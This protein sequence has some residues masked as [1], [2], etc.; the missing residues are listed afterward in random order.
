[1]K[2]S[3]IKI[4]HVFIFLF[5]IIIFCSILSYIVPSG[6]FER[7]KRVINKVEQNVVVP[8]SYI[9]IPKY[10]SIKGV[11]IGDKVEGYAMPNS[12]FSVLIA[13]PK[14][15]SQS[16]TL[17]FFV[18]ILGAVFNLIVETKTIHAFLSELIKR[19]IKFPILLFFLIYLTIST[20]SAFMGIYLELL[21]L[22]PI[23]MILAKQNGYDAMFGFALGILPVYI[24]WSTAT[25]NPFTVQI[26]QQI[27]ELPIG[28][29]FGLRF[30]IFILGIIIG[31]SYLMRYG[32]RVKNKKIVSLTECE[33]FSAVDGNEI[34]NVKLTIKHILILIVLLIGYACILSAVQFMGWGLMEMSAGFLAIGIAVIFISGWSGDKS[35]EIF[36]EGLKSMIIPALI[37]GV[38]RG[39][40]VVMV[41]SQI[42]DS[43]LF[44]FSNTLANQSQSIAVTGMLI[45]QSFLN[46]FIP[47][48]SGQALVSMPLMTPLSDLLGFSRQTAVLA[49][50]FGDGFSNM[51]IPTN[52]VLMA[53]LGIGGISFGKWLRF[54]L[55]VFWILL[56]LA[57]I[58]VILSVKIGYN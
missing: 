4:P 31:F 50:V 10:L 25:T 29:G 9:E 22:I 42:M 18:F 19:F 8:G 40:S 17:I 43:I 47:S 52:G 58:T 20:G 11:L 16:A 14:G 51:I 39:I 45:F 48:A 32:N 37:V 35:M 2:I 21:P 54:V 1:M 34:R 13:I 26:A 27:A 53:M 55:P 33:E 6:S 46:F 38:A 49:F 28:S 41:E 23:L 12:I 57:I 7:T 24:G 44:Y 56:I 30:V 5:L 36:T 3:Q 15:L